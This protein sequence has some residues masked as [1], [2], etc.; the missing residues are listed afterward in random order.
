MPFPPEFVRWVEQQ[1]AELQSQLD[2]LESG[3]TNLG[4]RPTGGEWADITQEEIA[5]IRK[6]VADLQFVLD[7]HREEE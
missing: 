6:H 5:R 2:L 1:Q 4:K 7:K 3:R